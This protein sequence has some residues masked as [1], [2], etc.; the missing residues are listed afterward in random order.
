MAISTNDQ[1][2]DKEKFDANFDAIFGKPKPI[3]RGSF[4]QD[5]KTGKL[6]PR[7]TV[8]TTPRSAVIMRGIEEFQSPI[9]GQVISSRQQLAA[10]NKKHGVTNASD[11][12]PNYIENKAHERVNAGK[13][14]LNETR[15]SDIGSAIDDHTR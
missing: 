2:V 14:Y 13:K 6:V 3:E 10:H 12:S 15:R 1:K 9:D 11:Y 8:P 7:G 4:T 5:P